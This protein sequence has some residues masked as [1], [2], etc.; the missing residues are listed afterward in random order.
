MPLAFARDRLSRVDLMAQAAA[1]APPIEVAPDRYRRIL[2]VLIP[3]VGLAAAV[4][5]ATAPTVVRFLG[6]GAHAATFVAL[7]A[8]A[9]ATSVFSVR[10]SRVPGSMSFESVVVLLTVILYGGAV[11]AVVAGGA[12]LIPNVVHRTA[13]IKI[14][15]NGASGVLQAA[16]AGAVASLVSGSRRPADV[17]AASA[18]ATLAFYGV[19]LCVM[20]IAFARTTSAPKLRLLED[21]IRGMALPVLFVMSLVP[22]VVAASHESPLLV[23]AAAGPLTAIG[24]VQARAL[25]VATATTLALTDPLTGLGN[26]RHFEERLAHELDAAE[27]GGSLVSVCL[28]DLDDFKM[29]NDSYGHAAG[30]AVLISAA[31]CLRRGGEAFRHGGDEFALLLPRCSEAAAAEVAA[32]VC[33]RIGE[34]EDPGGQ[35]LSSSA[36][37]GTFSPS[38][39]SERSDLLRA[40]DAA[41]Y[42]HKSERRR[43]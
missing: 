17:L 32:A 24:L 25:E 41:L 28:I 26:R 9:A 35:K 27:R 11:G 10:S 14:A 1:L 19:N 18:G 29:I 36:G 33:A 5:A 2:V 7:L 34:L 12:A 39:R 42:A 4:L 38:A 37:T 6:D 3:V 30:D 15:F 8:A 43:S 13:P 31:S 22:L 21:M 40:A 16:A 20:Y 23:I